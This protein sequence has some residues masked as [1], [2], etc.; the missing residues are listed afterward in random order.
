MPLALQELVKLIENLGYTITP[1]SP[2]K[3][4]ISIVDELLG[5]FAEATPSEKTSSELIRELRESGYGRY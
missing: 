3:E 2:T 1:A 4:K 5:V